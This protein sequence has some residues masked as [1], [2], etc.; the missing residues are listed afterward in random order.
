MMQPQCK[1]ADK[2]VVGVVG[3]LASLPILFSVPSDTA[4]GQRDHR[5]PAHVKVIASGLDNPRGLAFGP[6][7]ALY[8]AEAGHGGD[9]PCTDFELFGDILCYGPTGAVTRIWRGS[10]T[11]IATGLGSSAHP[12]GGFAFGPHDIAFNGRGEAYVIVGGCFPPEGVSVGCGQ[13]L[14]LPASG[15]W[16]TVADLTAYELLNNPDG[17]RAGESDPYAVLALAGERI[18]TDAAGNDLLR[19]APNGSISTL[20]VFPQ[21]SVEYPPGSGTQVLMDAVPTTVAVG[22]DGA[23]LRG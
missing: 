13:L 5:Q 10:Q 7:G 15:K 21:R 18:A 23:L 19:I 14:R 9:G 3:F 2:V 22:P 4:A 8:V 20:A 12:D 1:V 16:R 6:E 17:A 11:R